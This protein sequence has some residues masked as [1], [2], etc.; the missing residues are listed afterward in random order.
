[1]LTEDKTKM[2]IAVFDSGVG[3]ISVLKAI[4]RLMPWENYIFFGDSENA[5][6]GEK[7][8]DEVLRLTSKGVEYLLSQGAKAVVLACNTATS[9]AAKILREKYRDIPIIGLEPAVKP[10][11]LYP[12]PDKKAS[13]RILVMATPLTLREE[14]FLNLVEKYRLSAEIIPLPSPGLVR[15]VENELTG[16]DEIG[17]Y[18]SSLLAPYVKEP[19]DA[20][21]LGCTHFPFAK[22]DIKRVLGENVLFFDGAEGAAREL[23]H[24]LEARGTLLPENGGEKGGNIIFQNSDPGGSHLKLSQKLFKTDI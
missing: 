2:P 9:A 11:V 22:N 7:T 3:G 21:V 10:A 4:Y 24:Q 12:Y 6:Y 5:P 13:R 18:L 1:M 15:Y 19:V 17:E 8:T 23:K 20:V 14:K 16:G